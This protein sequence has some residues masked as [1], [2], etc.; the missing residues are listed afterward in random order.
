MNDPVFLS[1]GRDDDGDGRDQ[2]RRPYSGGGGGG[3][4][5]AIVAVAQAH[6]G[7]D[8]R[9]VSGIGHD[10]ETTGPV[11]AGRTG[12]AA[13]R[14]LSGG[15]HHA[16]LRRAGRTVERVRPALSVVGVRP[17]RAAVLTPVLVARQAAG[18][19]L[20]LRVQHRPVGGDS[21]R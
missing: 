5:I 7:R 14:Q 8:V 19:T 4:A 20:V 18:A 15:H 3:G 9:T 16:P 6:F 10:A 11:D 21:D 17:K 2:R 13:D 1:R 12:T